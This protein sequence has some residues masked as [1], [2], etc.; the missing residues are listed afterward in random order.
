MIGIIHSKKL[1]Q[2]NNIIVTIDTYKKKPIRNDIQYII[3]QTIFIS[4][5]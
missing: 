4:K 1:K 5:I 3:R 2:N